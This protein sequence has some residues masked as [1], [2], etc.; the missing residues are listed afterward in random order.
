MVKSVKRKHLLNILG[1]AVVAF[2][3]IMI[4]LMV[5][6]EDLEHLSEGVNNG[7]AK[8]LIDSKER[9]WKE[10]FLKGKK[11]GYSINIIQPFGDGYYIQEEIFLRLNLMGVERGLYTITQSGVDEDF[12]LKNFNFKM[13]SGVISYNISGKVEGNQ[14]VVMTGEGRRRRR[15]SIQLSEPPTIGA[16][17]EYMFKTLGMNVGDSYKIPFFDPSTMSQNEVVFK[18]VAQEPLKIKDITYNAF[19]VETEMWGNRLT[20]WLDEEGNVLKEEGFMGLVMIKSSAANAPLGIEGDEDTDF[21]EMTAVPVDR[22]LPNP[23]RLSYLKLDLDGVEDSDITRDAWA[24][25]RQELSDG[26][27][28]EVRLEEIPLM[29]S[30][31]IPYDQHDQELTPFLASEF[32]IESDVDEIRQ[33][34]RHI[35]G[36]EKDPVNASR[37]LLNWVYHNL[38]KRP[39]VNVP[40]ALEV[41]ETRMGDCNEHAVLLT[42]LLRASGIPARLSIGLVYNQRRFFYHAWTEAY[43]GEWISM[44]ATLNQ[45]PADLSHVRLISGNFDKQVEIMGLI[46]KL[47]IQVL[48]F[49]YDRTNSSDQGF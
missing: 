26:D 45:M 15:Q 48:D 6:R 20:F 4:G 46:G 27:I 34:A 14:L 7:I 9:E 2:W 49:G 13:N 38:D 25:G 35:L 43:V 3:I 29:G 1:I 42:A 31:S 5:K 41:L 22:D 39:V 21:Y 33:K 30:Y 28:I 8:P 32:N 44:D 40:S 10:I 47:N 24:G 19:R 23:E 37:R 12:I 18:V 11:V 17:M 36:E 16:G